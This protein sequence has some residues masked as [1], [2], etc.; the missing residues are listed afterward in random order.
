MLKRA[1]VLA[2]CLAGVGQAALLRVEI[3]EHS[4]VLAAKFFGSALPMSG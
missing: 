3:S 1:S 4:D 2:L